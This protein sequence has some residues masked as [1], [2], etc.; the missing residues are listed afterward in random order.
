MRCI[1]CLLVLL[2]GCSHPTSTVTVNDQAPEEQIE[3]PT[4]PPDG[5]R[6]WLDRR[7]QVRRD[8][9]AIQ[10]E[11]ESA[12]NGNWR[13]WEDDTARYRV[14]LKTR[15]A[16]L[17][18]IDALNYEALAGRDMPIFEGN[19]RMN[20]AHV[21][22]P[23]HWDVFRKTRPVVA[24]SRW[25]RDR[26]IDLIFVAVPTMPEV[27]IEQFLDETP[28]DGVIA[29]HLRQTFL[30]LL[31]SDVEVVNTFRLMREVHNQGFQYLPADHHWNQLGMRRTVRDV[32]SRLA[33]HQFGQ[34]VRNASPLT[35]VRRGPYL[36]PHTDNGPSWLASARPSITDNQWKAATGTLPRAMDYITSPD[37][38]LV[39]DDPGSPVMLI[40]NSFAMHFRELLIRE[41]NLRLRTRWG[42]GYT[43]GA[44]AGFLREPE[45]LEGNRVIVWVTSED[46]ICQF[47]PMPPSIMAALRDTK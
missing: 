38:S 33:R 26:S 7:S 34:E 22:D 30:E 41:A 20:L 42:N 29:P 40:G 3:A 21:L 46:T 19:P 17:K 5:S 31:E 14:A 1:G 16:R 35:R 39:P 18:R 44:F 23:E 36:L 37:G 8:A 13:K 6:A 12:A 28:P 9:Y 10:S 25:L 24:A 32:A 11:C 47:L 4:L 15:L 2:T 45:M 43:T 27:Y